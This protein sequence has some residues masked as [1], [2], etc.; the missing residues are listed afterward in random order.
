MIY[1]N[2]T[3]LSSSIYPNSLHI[4][5]LSSI[6]V[7]RK[8]RKFEVIEGLDVSEQTFLY[9]YKSRHLKLLS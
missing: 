9:S 4:I 1:I 6:L 5:Y 8:V 3:L 7:R 2:E